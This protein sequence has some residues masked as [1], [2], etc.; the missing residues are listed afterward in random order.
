MPAWEQ[1]RM[2]LGSGHSELVK[3][4]GGKQGE[5][6]SVYYIPREVNIGTVKKLILTLIS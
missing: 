2:R 1:N 4:C 5:D 3:G 6:G